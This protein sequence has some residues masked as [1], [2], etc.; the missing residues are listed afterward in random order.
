[1]WSTENSRFCEKYIEKQPKTSQNSL[2]SAVFWSEW[3]DSNLRHRRPKR[4]AL[5]TAPHPEVWKIL[6]FWGFSVSG[7]TCGQTAFYSDFAREYSAEKVSVYK[8]FRRFSGIHN[9]GTVSCSQTSRATNCATPRFCY[10]LI[11]SKNLP[12]VN[13]YGQIIF[14]F[15]QQ[16]RAKKKWPLIASIFLTTKGHFCS[17]LVSNVIWSTSLS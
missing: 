4:R 1:M 10:L 14:N 17:F 3:Q 16:G 5:P 15:L 6:N 7:Q 8:A 9:E 12:K 13:I 2:F 11:I